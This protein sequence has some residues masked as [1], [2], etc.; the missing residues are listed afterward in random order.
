MNDPDEHEAITG[1]TL[2]IEEV[3][4]KNWRKYIEITPMESHEA[5]KVM[6]YFIEEVKDR[7]MKNAL[8][9]ALKRHRPFAKF[10][11]IVESSACRQQ[12][13]D[14]RQKEW[15][16]YAWSRIEEQS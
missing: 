2:K 7:Q 14:F 11:S 16:K 1:E 3:K 8:I 5:F 12:W 15:G 9:T 4:H 10:K 6:E 13:F